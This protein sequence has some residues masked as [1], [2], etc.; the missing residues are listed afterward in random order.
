[1]A[2]LAVWLRDA[3]PRLTDL[4]LERTVRRRGI[5]RVG[6]LA[7]RAGLRIRTTPHAHGPW[8]HEHVHVQAGTALTRRLGHAQRHS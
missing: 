7:L 6:L 5:D 1:M 2:G 3:L 8:T 4:G